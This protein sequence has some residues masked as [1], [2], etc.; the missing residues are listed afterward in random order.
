M[1]PEGHEVRVTNLYDEN[2][3]PALGREE[4]KGFL[5]AFREDRVEEDVKG[6]VDNLLWCSGL[7]LCYPTWWYSFPAILKVTMWCDLNLQ[8]SRL[9]RYD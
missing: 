6:H 2:F 3:Q 7:V 5:T 9:Q 1:R 4:A 8:D